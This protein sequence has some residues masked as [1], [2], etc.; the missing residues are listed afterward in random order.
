MKTWQTGDGQTIRRVLG[1]RSNAFLLSCGTQHVL[2]DAGPGLGYP[3]LRRN[4]ARLGIRQDDLA[5]LVLTHA[6]F[7]HAE[8]ANRVQRDY[9]TSI[10]IQRED[11]G[12]L[13]RGENPMIVGTTRLTRPLTNL[14]GKRVLS[15]AHYPPVTPDITFDESFDLNPLGV[16]AY[17]L[18]TPG[19]SPGSASIVVNRKIALVGDTLFGVFRNAAFPPFADLPLMLITSWKKL[20][21]TGCTLFLPSHGQAVTRE[22]LQREYVKYHKRAE[23]FSGGTEQRPIL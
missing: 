6:H 4:L 19:H 9:K 5:A 3:V 18:H 14:L 1:G 10:I 15:L 7:D 20:L 12:C 17:L 21:D 11:A 8:N 13:S 16:N 23:A 2:I 22:L